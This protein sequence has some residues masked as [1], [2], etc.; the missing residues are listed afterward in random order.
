MNFS[1][2]GFIAS[3]I[4][5]GKADPILV[6]YASVRI[7]KDITNEELVLFGDFVVAMKTN[8]QSDAYSLTNALKEYQAKN[9]IELIRDTSPFKTLLEL[10]NF[11]NEY[12]KGKII[13]SGVKPFIYANI[14]LNAELKLINENTGR[15]LNA[16]DESELMRNL[17]ENQ[18]LIGVYRPDL[19]SE[20][21]KRRDSIVLDIEEMSELEKIDAKAYKIDKEKT[22]EAWSRL[23]SKKVV[24]SFVKG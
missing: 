12:L 14:S 16:E 9:Y 13:A 8:F 17:L 23:L 21:I 22:N 11:I 20:R 4:F 24:V 6:E 10:R 1:R 15:Q 19:I 2:K 5:K 3:V 18:N 7:L